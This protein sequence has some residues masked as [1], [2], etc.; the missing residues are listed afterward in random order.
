MDDSKLCSSNEQDC[1]KLQIAL[2]FYK[3]LQN[4]ITED[5]NLLLLADLCDVKLSSTQGENRVDERELLHEMA[6]KFSA[7]VGFVALRSLHREVQSIKGCM[8]EMRE[9]MTKKKER[10]KYTIAETDLKLSEERK[11]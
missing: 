11:N 6:S 10:R 2:A 9:K 7:D 1:T 3:E 5:E 4:N 8:I